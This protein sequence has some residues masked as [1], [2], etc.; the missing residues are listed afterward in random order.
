LIKLLLIIYQTNGVVCNSPAILKYCNNQR[1]RSEGVYFNIHL[2]VANFSVC[3]E[4]ITM[5]VCYKIFS[6]IA[7]H[8][9]LMSSKKAE[10]KP[11]L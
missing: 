5:V 9:I 3:Q 8:N 10:P 4:L 6:E 11:Y 2:V 7:T 1:L